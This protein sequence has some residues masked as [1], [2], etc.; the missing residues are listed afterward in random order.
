[1]TR[2][3][4]PSALLLAAVTVLLLVA[5]AG[6][7]AA[8]PPEPRQALLFLVDRVSFEELM[9]V[10][11]FRQL[12]RA[13]GAG[14][15]T[16][17]RSGGS[18]LRPY[19]A[20]GDGTLPASGLGRRTLLSAA[21]QRFGVG[22][23]AVGGSSSAGVTYTPTASVLGITQAFSGAT[24]E[25]GV[26]KRLD[27]SF[28]GRLRTSPGAILRFLRGLAGG[29]SARDAATR[30]DEGLLVVVDTGD[31]LRV[32][33][34]AKE[35]GPRRASR[36][37]R[38]SALAAGHLVRQAVEGIEW[39]GRTLVLVVTAYPSSQMDRLGDVV[40]P[41]VMAEGS[42]GEL[43]RSEGPV[44]GLTSDSTQQPGLVSN[45]DVA[46]TVLRFL[47]A[48]IPS[49]MVGAP[50]HVTDEP[51]PFALHARHL[52]HR[53]I[54]FP[55]QI[56]EVAFVSLGGLVVILALAAVALGHR[57]PARLNAGLRFLCLFATALP[58][59]LL[60]G[61]SLPRLTYAV[62]V[63][64][65]VMAPAIVAGLSLGTRGRGAF[66]PFAFIGV[67]GLAALC[68]D[69][70]LGGPSFRTPLLGG[71]MFEGAR[72]YGLP[73]AFIAPLAAS[74]LFVAWALPPF[75][76]SLL[77]AAAG[78]FAGFP[79]LG[80]NVGASITLF[81]AAG[82]WWPLRARGKLRARELA[83]AV[84]VVVLGLAAVLLANSFLAG[85]PTHAGRFVERTG[86]RLD[87]L[88]ETI[89]SRLSV[90]AE[91]LR[92]AP[93]ALIPLL[94][95]PLL[96]WVALAGPRP[97][98]RAVSADLAWR[99]VL[100]VLV[101][102]SLVA[103]FANDTGLAAAAPSFLYAMAVVAYPV[104]MAAASSPHVPVLPPSSSKAE[105]VSSARSAGRT[106]TGR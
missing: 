57:L 90:G 42:A 58:I 98:T 78:L 15:M 72:F 91:Q 59:A 20:I 4:R 68:L 23:C 50:I 97:V 29:S 21:L 80:A 17:S 103:Y 33:R 96:L 48:P 54:R 6:P 5:C 46:P 83:S 44:H 2:P 31:T 71:T 11:E 65:V 40:T 93:A 51:A 67:V 53:R 25:G 34:Y 106:P 18:Q 41:I 35:L 45:L 28:P 49:E 56:A 12:A 75:Q 27:P 105:V 16:P 24:C 10:P 77:L 9:A 39:P 86:G 66:A 38:S 62:V 79:G 88:V 87:E 84:A 99:D 82:L 61:G 22:T 69:A 95:L 81:A 100:I 3:G 102:G 14:L 94:G 73:N 76:G 7:A 1:M 55:L 85:T 74:A 26:A 64:F 89:G 47:G 92:A 60:V 43:L 36:L 13:G 104:L 30:Q 8:A 37:R 70:L 52:E 32:D 63:P 101:L 19:R